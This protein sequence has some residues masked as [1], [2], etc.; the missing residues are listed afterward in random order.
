MHRDAAA[1]YDQTTLTTTAGTGVTPSQ[2]PDTWG[3]YRLANKVGEGSYGSV[4]RA[5]DSELEFDVALK[6]LHRRVGDTR[7]RE[8][9]LQE[10]R[11][12]AKIQHNNVVR[13]LGIEANGDRVG[14]WMESSCGARR[15]PT[16]CE[17]RAN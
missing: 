3:K 6:I 4:Y 14:L 11:A 7:L 5:W 17:A 10:G 9:L 16:S 2:A 15:W 12:L 1:D 8:R 13:V